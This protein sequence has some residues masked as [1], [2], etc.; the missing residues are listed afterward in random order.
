VDLAVPMGILL[1]VLAGAALTA[2][3]FYAVVWLTGTLM[4]WLVGLAWPAAGPVVAHVWKLVMGWWAVV[5]WFLF[6]TKDGYSRSRTRH[7]RSWR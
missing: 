4:G 7:E 1:V 6:T 2:L 5:A 3:F